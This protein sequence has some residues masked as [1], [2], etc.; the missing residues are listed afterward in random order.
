MRN[1]ILLL[2]LI[3]LFLSSC[4]HTSP[5]EKDLLT[6]A[7]SLM[8]SHPDSALSLL[9]TINHSAK[10]SASDHAL[11]ALLL[12]QA[13]YK[14]DLYDQ[15][16]NSDSL[17]D[18]AVNYYSHH[19]DP[20]KRAYAYFYLSRSVRYQND[21]QG[22]V[23]A[24]LEA[25]PFAIQS[26]NNKLLGLVYGE[27]ASAYEDQQNNLFDSTND[28]AHTKMTSLEI[29][30]KDQRLYYNKLSLSAFQN[31]KD[32]RN[33]AIGLLDI[34]NNYYQLN[35]FDSALS[36]CQKARPILF[37]LHETPL[38]TTLYRLMA[39]IYL[40][41]KKYDKALQSIRLS[42]QTS[43]PLDYDKWYVY[44]T[45][46]MRTNELD[47]ARIYL[48]R[49]AD[50]GHKQQECYQLLQVIAEKQG[51]VQSALHYAKLTTAAKDSIAQSSLM[52]N[53]S[54]VNKKY[55]YE[56]LIVENKQ[57]VI[58]TQRYL[59]ASL[60]ALFF[61]GLLAFFYFIERGREKKLA[62]LEISL[63]KTSDA[64]DKFFSIISH[65]L[66]N[67][68]FAIKLLSEQLYQHV[69]HLEK[70]K[71]KELLKALFNAAK[72]NNKLTENLLNWA[73][74]QKSDFVINPSAFDVKEVVENV[75]ETIRADVEL[76]QITLKLYFNILLL[77]LLIAT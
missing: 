41:Q 14:C 20:G 5:K 73:A 29:E 25:I 6:R 43:D 56:R 45:I 10:L 23:K 28:T 61:C 33:Y 57:L 15:K 53:I 48:K 72:Q 70:E 65:D 52:E 16:H 12:T 46:C 75:V 8:E 32:T 24:L 27:I 60:L 9:K 7:E 76:K 77:Y 31:A 1:L 55:N 13:N 44:A 22:R 66:R 2:F 37:S 30:E 40:E 50:S 74:A 39:G 68:S 38:I 34:S 62:L 58:T 49:V 71:I 42:M 69:D 18:I 3:C 35:Q 19:N 67:P 47:S 26:H 51:H 63:R 17:I 64:K 21:A 59:I 54:E 36:Y 4:G 11:Y